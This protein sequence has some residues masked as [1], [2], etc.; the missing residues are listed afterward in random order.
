M[1]MMDPSRVFSLFDHLVGKREQLV[2]NLEAER[3]CGL[4]IDGHG[5]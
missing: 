3:P 1:L 2:W 5:C 4:E